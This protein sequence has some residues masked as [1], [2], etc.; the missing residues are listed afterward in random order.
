M[1]EQLAAFF[2]MLRKAGINAELHVYSA[3]GHG[4]GV[5]ATNH[6]PSGAWIDRFAEWLADRKFL[7]P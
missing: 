5:R 4:F 2:T 3:G 6:S 1:P 7:T